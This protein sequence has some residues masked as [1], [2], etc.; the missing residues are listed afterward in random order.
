MA[1]LRF[2]HKHIGTT[3]SKIAVFPLAQEKRPVFG[4]SANDLAA[5]GLPPEN[6]ILKSAYAW[7]QTTVFSRGLR[8]RGRTDQYCASVALIVVCVSTIVRLPCRS[9]SRKVSRKLP[10]IAVPGDH[11]CKP[12]QLSSLCGA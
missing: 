8:R 9:V 12:L 4:R 3:L 10:F 11:H 6:P 1:V 7:W 5:K 2:V